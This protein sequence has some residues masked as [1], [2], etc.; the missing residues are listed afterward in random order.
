MATNASVKFF[1][2]LH[3]LQPP[4]LSPYS[5]VDT[6]HPSSPVIVAC[7]LAFFLPCCYTTHSF[8]LCLP[9]G[10]MGHAVCAMWLLCVPW[11]CMGHAVCAM[12]LHDAWGMRCVPWG[13]GAGF[14]IYLFF[15]SFIISF[16]KPIHHINKSLLI[17]ICFF[18]SN[19]N[20]INIIDYIH[21]FFI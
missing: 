18:T 13:C 19:V 20:T 16:T 6:P 21:W 15:H 10:C 4:P 5:S 1:N 2:L 9:W 14:A 3:L 11:G 7:F 8:L 12:G 17:P